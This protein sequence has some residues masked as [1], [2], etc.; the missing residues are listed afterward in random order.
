MSDVRKWNINVEGGSDICQWIMVKGGPLLLVLP[1]VLH[2]LQ[3]F[4]NGP[5][6]GDVNF[7]PTLPQV[8]YTLQYWKVIG[9]PPDEQQTKIDEIDVNSGCD[10]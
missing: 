6:Q 1:D 2:C 5:P 10:F 7:T 4:K 9:L 8:L 3:A